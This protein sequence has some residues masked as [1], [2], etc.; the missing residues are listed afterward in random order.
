MPDREHTVFS[1]IIFTQSV[2]YKE[3]IAV[4]CDSNINV[5]V[6]HS[7]NKSQRDAL[8]LKF[9]LVKISTFEK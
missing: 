5:V 8:F 6:T 3:V 4:S 1:I 2:L 7:Y 9:I